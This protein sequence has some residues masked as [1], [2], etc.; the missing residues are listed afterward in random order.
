MLNKYPLW[1]NALIVLVLLVCGLYAAPNLFLTI[2]LF[3]FP[4]P[5]N[6]M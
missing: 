3:S 5:G 6:Q 1:K 2:M 4:V